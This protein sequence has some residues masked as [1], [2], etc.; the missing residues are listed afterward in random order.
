MVEVY[1]YLGRVIDLTRVYRGYMSKS[2]YYINAF[3]YSGTCTMDLFK[4]W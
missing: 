2:L 3:S 4:L 1:P